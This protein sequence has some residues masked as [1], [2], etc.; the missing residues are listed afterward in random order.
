M[1]SEQLAQLFKV[2]SV[3]TRVRIVQL[4]RREVLC[5][6]SLSR[7]LGVSQSA[8]SQHLRILRNA[9]LVKAERR[10]YFMHY[11]LDPKTTSRWETEIAGFLGSMAEPGSQ[12]SNTK[13]EQGMCC[14]KKRND[15][16]KPEKLEG[17]PQECS[18]EQIRECHGSDDKHPCT[19]QESSG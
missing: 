15:C 11:R 5:V 14:E 13:E 7:R 12:A 6:G 17:K 10:G 3:P 8:V 16:Q 9:R 18:P 2:L 19:T 1:D 4:L